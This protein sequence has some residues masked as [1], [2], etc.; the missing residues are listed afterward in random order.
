MTLVFIHRLYQ[1][2]Y[3]S[4]NHIGSLTC[5]LPQ[6]NQFVHNNTSR[7]ENITQKTSTVIMNTLKH[8]LLFFS[9]KTNCNL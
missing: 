4:Q 9:N 3:F 6:F 5:K 2:F 7:F 1:Q 8:R